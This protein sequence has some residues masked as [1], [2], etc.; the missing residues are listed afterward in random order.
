MWS[1]ANAIYNNRVSHQLA[2]IP[3]L[4]PGE[5][6]SLLSSALSLDTVPNDIQAQVI[7]A[8]L[9]GVRAVFITFTALA[10]L[11]LLC[12]L[13]LKEVPFRKD[14]PELEAEKRRW[15]EKKSLQS[16]AEAG[17]VQER[18]HDES[19]DEKAPQ[20]DRR[21]ST[22]TGST[23]ADPPLETLDEVTGLEVDAA[24]ETTETKSRVRE[25]G[26]RASEPR[27]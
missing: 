16:V 6:K 5:Q 17:N 2:T 24:P 1:V 21:G 15:K 20:P 23:L 8:Y 9:H 12:A 11:V 26:R 14:S 3:G 10:G 18:T 22:A 4:A 19:Q 27:T 13:C 25:G 7:D